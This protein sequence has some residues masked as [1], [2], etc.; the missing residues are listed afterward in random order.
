MHLRGQDSR[1]ARR[2]VWARTCVRT[3]TQP[4]S[5][6]QG[7]SVTIEAM[8]KWEVPVVA[9][10]LTNPTSIHENVSLIPGLAQ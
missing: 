10:Q 6:A 4:D 5:R 8:S 3:A 7:S 1:G 2:H 9:Q